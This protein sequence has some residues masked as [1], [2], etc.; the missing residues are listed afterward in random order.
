MARVN[1]C[2]L[3]KLEIIRVATKNFL[4]NGYTKTQVRAIAREL[5]MSP[6][7]L[8]FHYP[9]KEYMLA[10]LVN[11]LCKFQWELMEEE[12]QEGHSSIMA[13]CL[14]L[15]T[16]AAT[17]DD[18]E[19]AK[20]FFISAYANP[21]CLSIIRNN[22]TDRA[23]VLFKDYCEGWSDERFAQAEI[24]VSGIEFATFMTAGEPVPLEKRIKGALNSILAIYNVPKEI[25]KAKI[26]KVLSMDYKYLGQKV[27]RDFKKYVDESNEQALL[28]LL[29]G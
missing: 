8:T 13:L 10:E 2:E 5:N 11:L 25:R 21:L 20:D 1:R 29:K 9:T 24:I 17:C 4:E 26:A 28:A 12:A 7:N 3:T 18:D 19:S 15:A 22:D 14:E 23:K 6:G 27:L 16:M